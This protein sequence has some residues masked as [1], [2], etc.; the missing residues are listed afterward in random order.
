MTA[1]KINA[2]DYDT[3]VE[4]KGL[5]LLPIPKSWGDLD[6]M[7]SSAIKNAVDDPSFKKKFLASLPGETSEDVRQILTDAALVGVPGAQECGWDPPPT[8]LSMMSEKDNSNTGRGLLGGGLNPLGLLQDLFEHLPSL[9]PSTVGNW[10]GAGVDIGAPKTRNSSLLPTSLTPSILSQGSGTSGSSSRPR[11]T[12]SAP[13]PVSQLCIV[14]NGGYALKWKTHSCTHNVM[15]GYSGVF[16]I[17]QQLCVELEDVF[18]NAIKEDDVV[19]PGVQVGDDV[20]RPRVQVVGRV[21]NARRIV[22]DETTL[23][24]T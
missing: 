16:P 2:T 3:E 11:G 20:V 21:S 14:N 23:S 9:S 13:L 4:V 17:D 8:L 7:V 10:L 6:E 15:T 18:P 22:S 12:R 5:D 19:R 24:E 1:L